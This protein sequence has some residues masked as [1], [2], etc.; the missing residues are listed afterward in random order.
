MRNGG[1]PPAHLPS[2]TV[3]PLDPL[4]WLVPPQCAS[5][6]QPLVRESDAATSPLAHYDEIISQRMIS[7]YNQALAKCAKLAVHAQGVETAQSVAL[8]A[9]RRQEDA[10]HAQALAN[11]VDI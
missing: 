3:T 9:W 8:S 1:L 4:R 5:E 2:S 11:E 10:A 7:L 6:P